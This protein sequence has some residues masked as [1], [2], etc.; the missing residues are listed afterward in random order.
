[1]WKGAVVCQGWDDRKLSVE[2]ETGK[3][4]TNTD[5]NLIVL[6]IFWFICDVLR[7]CLSDVCLFVYCCLLVGWFVCLCL[8]GC[9]LLFV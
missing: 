5:S 1:M 3:V 2:D 6:L 8:S 4:S 9:L 7:I